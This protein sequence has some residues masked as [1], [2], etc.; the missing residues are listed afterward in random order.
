M[1]L[2][3]SEQG[4]RTWV[5]LRMHSYP[6]LRCRLHVQWNHIEYIAVDACGFWKVCAESSVQQVLRTRDVDSFG[7]DGGDEPYLV[8]E[9]HA[10][11]PYDGEVLF[12]DFVVDD[13]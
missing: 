13:C 1:E 12:A 10:G 4:V 3:A 11:L 6:I 8:M 2:L 5:L 9:G 7:T